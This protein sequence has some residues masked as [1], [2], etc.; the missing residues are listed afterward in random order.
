MDKINNLKK[1]DTLEM[2]IEDI[3][4]DGEGIGKANGIA[5]FVKDALIGDHILAK[6]M[7]MKKNY[8]YARLMEIITPSP[9]RVE[10]KCTISRQ[11][12]GCQLQALSYEKQ[13][14]FKREKVLN[15]LKRIGGFT[16]I[17]VE[18]V[19]GMEEPYHYRNKAQYPIGYDKNGKLTA[20]FYAART[21]SLVPVT[22]CYIGAEQNDEILNKIL[23]V[24]E[25]NHINPYDEASHRGQIR[26]IL[27]RVG[28]TT[29]E[30]MVCIVI[31]GKKLQ[32]QEKFIQALSALENMT[33]ISININQQRTNVILGDTTK[34]I[35]G[36]DKITDYI[37]DVKYAISPQSFYQV[38]AIQ[39]KKL[40]DKVMEYADLQGNETVWDLYCG[41]G[42]I[43]LFLA[44]KAKK[45]YGVEIVPQAIADAKENA[46]LNNFENTEFFT[47]KAEEV[48]PKLYS[49]NKET[50]DVI[51]VDPP[52]KGCEMSLLETM[53]SMQPKRIVY[54]SCD[55]AT[56]AR[57]LKYLCATDY[58][59]TK[60]QPVDLFCHTGHVETVILMTH[61]SKIDK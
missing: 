21:H 16:D 54:V 36:S 60:V 7:K 47:G 1:D 57:D 41:I 45:V 42:T 27:I 29:K 50:V 59:I 30:I 58:D 39:T 22:H 28:N 46:A 3:G 56:L 17:T 19:I 25:E 43:S 15:H 8:G 48:L 32:F 6:V 35:W 55:S 51:I 40:Y 38:N 11:C 37:G 9:W 12:G 10:P 5:L 34:T 2:V 52:R 14:E 23:L 31:N 20:G 61:C 33:S 18:P 44:Q 26:H 53:L 24:M 49:E 4:E 13:L